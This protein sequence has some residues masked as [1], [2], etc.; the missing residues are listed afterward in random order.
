MMPEIVY[1][2]PL[3]RLDIPAEEKANLAGYAKQYGVTSPAPSDRR[4][5][6][7]AKHVVLRAY[8]KAY[9]LR[10]FVETGTNEGEAVVQMLRA[11][12]PVGLVVT[13]EIGEGQPGM[14]NFDAVAARLLPHMGRVKM[15]RGDSARLLPQM[16][17]SFDGPYLAWL[18]AHA[19]GPEDPDP[20]HFPLRAELAYLCGPG[21]RPGSVILVDDARFFGFGFWPRLEEVMLLGRECS[22]SD[23]IVRVIL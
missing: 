13:V 19:N 21:A 23:D 5:H 6:A 11:P 20:T 9:G 15:F 16:L 8:A 14:G 2:S 22:L 10:T 18:D 7:D 17:A 4:L 12:S 1:E 3:N